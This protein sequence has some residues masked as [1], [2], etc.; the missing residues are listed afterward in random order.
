[1]IFSCFS[2]GSLSYLHTPTNYI[3]IGDLVFNISYLPILSTKHSI[4]IPTSNFNISESK[5]SVKRISNMNEVKLVFPAHDLNPNGISI[6][7]FGKFA[8]QI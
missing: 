7:E 6:E 3:L 1:M 4:S 2:K 8:Q 5:K